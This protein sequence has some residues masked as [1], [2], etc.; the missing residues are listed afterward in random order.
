MR[1]ILS[2]AISVK[3]EAVSHSYGSARSHSRACAKCPRVSWLLTAE[4]AV[5]RAGRLRAQ[6]DSEKRGRA[7]VALRVRVQA[8]RDLA[9]AN[10]RKV[11]L[12]SYLSWG[13]VRGHLRKCSAAYSECLLG[14]L[15]GLKQLFCTYCATNWTFP[16]VRSTRSVGL[17]TLPSAYLGSS[18]VGPAL[19]QESLWPLP[20]TSCRPLG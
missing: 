7:E 3:L 6:K 9:G 15:W 1:N 4:S 8:L 11:C 17:R 19:F 18:R 10:F 13:V 5:R 16:A 20:T 14:S 2:R 12:W